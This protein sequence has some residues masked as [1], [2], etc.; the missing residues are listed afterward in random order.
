MR[1]SALPEKEKR[2]FIKQFRISRHNRHE[3]HTQTLLNVSSFDT[4]TIATQAINTSVAAAAAIQTT[5]TTTLNLLNQNDDFDDEATSLHN[6]NQSSL[7]IFRKQYEF[8]NASESQ[9]FITTIITKKKPKN[10]LSDISFDES[11]HKKKK[12]KPSLS[13]QNLVNETEAST[14][15]L[16]LYNHRN[17][18]TQHF[19]FTGWD[20]YFDRFHKISTNQSQII[21]NQLLS[22]NNEQNNELAQQT[23]TN[24]NENN[25][26]TTSQYGKSERLKFKVSFF[27]Q[28]RTTAY[29]NLPLGNHS[30]AV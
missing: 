29:L 10:D 3:Q 19:L 2:A 7:K 11:Q 6:K 22:R 8:N 16:N 15:T 18:D 25:D 9:S 27:Q 24:I 26:S 23:V 4:T 30:K 28:S 12:L 1:L 21:R 5:I 14:S 13:S 20:D 17:N